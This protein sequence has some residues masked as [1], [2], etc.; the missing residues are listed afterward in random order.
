MPAASCPLVLTPLELGFEQTGAPTPGSGKSWLGCNRHVLYLWELSLE[1]LAS[2]VRLEIQMR[3]LLS[4]R[5][6]ALLIFSVRLGKSC[7]P[8]RTW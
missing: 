7:L 5:E 8:H 2:P 6:L 4:T 3:D 1:H